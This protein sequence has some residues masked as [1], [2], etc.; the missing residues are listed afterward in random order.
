MGRQLPAFQSVAVGRCTGCRPPSRAENFAADCRSF[1]GVLGSALSNLESALR[2]AIH[3]KLAS[4]GV[5]QLT[6]LRTPGIR[7]PQAA[8]RAGLAVGGD[9]S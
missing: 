6:T 3:R 1:L 5:V 9:F 2:G 4:G 8:G 7:C